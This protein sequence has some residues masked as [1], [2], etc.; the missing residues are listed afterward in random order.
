V[1]PVLDALAAAAGRW[2]AT[3][4]GRDS[5]SITY[6][7]ASSLR[8]LRELSLD[9]IVKIN[10][11]EGRDTSPMY[12]SDWPLRRRLC[13]AAS[14][15]ERMAPRH[16]SGTGFCESPLRPLGDASPQLNSPIRYGTGLSEL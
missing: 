2:V 11:Q 8:G 12:R 14:F 7:A 9:L 16:Q 13:D 3:V 1:A 10:V 5:N 4:N 6:D 15:R